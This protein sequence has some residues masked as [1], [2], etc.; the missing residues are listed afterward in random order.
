[1]FLCFVGLVYPYSGGPARRRQKEERPAAGDKGV[2]SV[3][4]R[5]TS[6]SPPSRIPETVHVHAQSA[7]QVKSPQRIVT[8]LLP[9][10]PQPRHYTSHVLVQRAFLPSVSTRDRPIYSPNPNHSWA[11][12]P[13]MR[14]R[15][16]ACA[17]VCVRACVRACVRR[18]WHACCVCSGLRGSGVEWARERACVCSEQAT[19]KSKCGVGGADTTGLVTLSLTT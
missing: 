19:L 1:M 14:P 13:R 10:N 7:L 12:A 4:P 16:R 8:R 17:C 15:G 9:N 18:A 5:Y 6:T 11:R 3:P 2:R